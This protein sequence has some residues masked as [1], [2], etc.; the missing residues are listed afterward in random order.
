[1]QGLQ[2]ELRTYATSEKPPKIKEK[3][4]QE[5]DFFN[6]QS[7]LRSMNRPRYQ[8]KEGRALHDINQAWAV[9]E[10]AE[11]D[12]E[13]ALIQELARLRKLDEEAKR[14]NK[15]NDNLNA[16]MSDAE[17]LVAANRQDS[18]SSI[19]GQPA[20]FQDPPFFFFFYQQPFYLSLSFF[21]DQPP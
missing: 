10:T 5:G 9:L 20:F 6:I 19:D 16:W 7:K 8:P 11:H 3:S 4:E 12:R 2:T 1:V 13:L 18:D 21:N 17:K 14:F 15:K